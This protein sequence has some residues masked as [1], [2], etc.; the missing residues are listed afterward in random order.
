[1]NRT[2]VMAAAIKPVKPG[3][4]LLGQARTVTGMVGDNGIS[5]A[6]IALARKGE[7]MVIDAGGYDDV[8]VWGGIMTRAAMKRG[9]AGVVIDAAIRDAAEIRELGFPCYARANVPA[10]PHK[11]FGGI[12]DGP[13]SCAGCPVK[14]GD[15]VIGDDDGIAVV[16]LEWAEDMLAA[17]KGKLRQEEETLKQIAEGKTTAELLGI[18]EPEIISE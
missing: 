9:I 12:I 8:A 2:H 15:L 11:G 5:H 4:R 10:G 13:I 3:I 17:S 14:P 18:G 16:P 7:V 1:M 6:A